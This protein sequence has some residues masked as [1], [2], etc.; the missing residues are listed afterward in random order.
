MG[1]KQQELR[2]QDYLVLGKLYSTRPGRVSVGQTSAPA[3]PLTPLE[4]F[5]IRNLHRITETP[6]PER[7]EY[8]IVYDFEAVL[9]AHA[10]LYILSRSQG[11]S[12]LSDLCISRLW[13]ELVELSAPEAKSRISDNVVKLLRYVYCSPRE[14]A[15][16]EALQP[17]WR[18]LQ[19]LSSQFCALNIHLMGTEPGFRT[20]L[21]EA[22]ALA[23]D[24]M[25]KTLRRLM[26]VESSPPSGYHPAAQGALSDWDGLAARDAAIRDFFRKP[27]DPTPVGPVFGQT[28]A[29]N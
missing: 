24:I 15:T 4:S 14:M 2:V 18:Q 8:P 20:L 27:E 7:L 12:A 25:D 19:D 28:P 11:V 10:R 23:T 29:T 13:G 16:P 5:E 22:G 6:P 9:L 21:Q 26:S 17:A 3:R 1:K